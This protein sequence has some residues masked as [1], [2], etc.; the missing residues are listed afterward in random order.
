MELPATTCYFTQTQKLNNKM[1]V[2][3]HKRHIVPGSNSTM[4]FTHSFFQKFM[5]P[6]WRKLILKRAPS[7]TTLLELTLES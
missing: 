2:S 6:L 7:T 3:I 4:S 1:F 5:Y